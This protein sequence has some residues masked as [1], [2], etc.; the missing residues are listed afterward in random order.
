MLACPGFLGEEHCIVTKRP[1]RRAW[2]FLGGE[3]ILGCSGDLVS[4]L[5]NGPYRASNGL[6]WW[7]VADTKWTY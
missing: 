7:L 1:G 2:M 5:S 6:L 4:R 3:L